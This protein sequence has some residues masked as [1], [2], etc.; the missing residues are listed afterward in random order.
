MLPNSLTIG[1]VQFKPQW[2]NVQRNLS[3]TLRFFSD[4]KNQGC[5]VVVLP[6][7]WPTGMYGDLDMHKFKE[8]I[9]GAYTDFLAREA[10][11][12]SFFIIAG[13]PERGKGKAL[14]NTAVLIGKDGRVIAKHRKV[15][16]YTRLGEQKIWTPGNEFT[17]VDTDFGKIGL[18]IC[19]DGDFP[20]SWRINAL[21]GADIVFHI[22]AYESPCEAWWD[23][24][25]PGAAF[26]NLLWV[27]MCN[28]VG[29]TVIGGKPLHLFGNSRIIA[30]DGEIACQAPYVSPGAKSESF[31]L[32]RRLDARRRL[33][34]ARTSFGNFLE[35]RRPELYG[36]LAKPSSHT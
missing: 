14:H 36:T 26:Q 8:P 16:P 10:S 2:G 25:Y 13:M 22:S 15:H 17:V 20:E 31:L 33:E 1:V 34:A 24:F 19:Y 30:P 18:L 23:K 12:H 6:E 4:A 9:P 35:D 28:T 7:M 29:D 27:V 32:V 11:K 5:E 21:L 3:E